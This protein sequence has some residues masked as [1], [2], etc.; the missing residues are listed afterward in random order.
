MTLR[1]AVDCVVFGVDDTA[2]KVLLIQ[3]KVP[4]FQGGWALPGG[5]VLPDE[6]IDAA[7]GR[8]LAE[9]T[10]LQNIF[11]EQLYTFGAVARDPRDRVVSVA[12]YAL[13]NLWEQSLHPT[14]DAEQA[15]WFEIHDLPALAFDHDQILQ[16]A[17]TR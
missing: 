6:S 9:E 5:F 16:I 2:L 3:R 7:A 15:A 10:G 17:L 12:Y 11:L 4:P 8:E 13:V 1:L 14:T